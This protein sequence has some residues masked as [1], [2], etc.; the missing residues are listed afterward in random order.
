MK[1]PQ[2]PSHLKHLLH[3]E[4]Q[5]F[6]TLRLF[7]GV[8]KQWPAFIL[9]FLQTPVSVHVS[10]H[11]SVNLEATVLLPRPEKQALQVAHLPLSLKPS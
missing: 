4:A 10:S 6:K 11:C 1:S 5:V 9:V 2:V 7:P 8:L 3:P